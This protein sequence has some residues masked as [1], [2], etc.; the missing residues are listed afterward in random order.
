MNATL[1]PQDLAAVLA[2][3][4]CSE[5]SWS[6]Q[7][8]AAW[9]GVSQSYLFYALER[10]RG[11]GLYRP[12]A[13]QVHVPGLLEFVEHGV[14][15]SFFVE[16]AGRTRGVPTAHSAPALSAELSSSPEAAVVWPAPNG[17]MVGQGLEPLY[18]QAIGTV[19][20]AP[21]LYEV[22][23]LVDAIR[24][25]RRRDSALAMEALRARVGSP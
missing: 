16:L 1:K 22:L 23:T 7:S 20:S 11:A 2:V 13:R 19:V 15:W 25:G 9:M 12:E 8:L 14:R 6:F 10:A 3:R 5:P 4:V 17:T 21:E 18:P 24:L